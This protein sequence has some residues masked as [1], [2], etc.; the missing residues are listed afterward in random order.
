MF[1]K[2]ILLNRS[3][4]TTSQMHEISEKYKF[5]RTI[6]MPVV[7]INKAIETYYI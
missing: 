6:V 2:V 7:G 1:R 4:F 5:T 3:T